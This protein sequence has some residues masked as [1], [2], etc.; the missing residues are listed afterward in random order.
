MVNW[1]LGSVKPWQGVGGML[2][3][4]MAKKATKRACGGVETVWRLCGWV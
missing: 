4:F 2:H 1:V 3:E